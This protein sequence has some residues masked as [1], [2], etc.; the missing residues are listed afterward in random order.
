MHGA[1]TEHFDGLEALNV[2]QVRAVVG[3]HWRRRVLEARDLTALVAPQLHVTCRTCRRSRNIVVTS[4]VDK[5][6]SEIICEQPAA[7]LG[8]GLQ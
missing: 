5:I 7:Q 2:E 8:G 3:E 4:Y 6:V 1:Q